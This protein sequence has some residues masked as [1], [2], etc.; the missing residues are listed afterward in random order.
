MVLGLDEEFR[1]LV[2]Y[3]SGEQDAL[4][5]GEVRILPERSGV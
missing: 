4:M 1:L 5:S 2:R 3:D